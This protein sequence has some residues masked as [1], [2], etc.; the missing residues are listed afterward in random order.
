MRKQQTHST[1]ARIVAYATLVM[2]TGSGMAIAQAPAPVAAPPPSPSANGADP[3]AKA[4]KTFSP[5]ELEQLLAPIALYPDSLL[6]QTLMASTYPL[7]V[8]SAER[9]L[10]AN[11]SLKGKALE[12][13][14]QKQTWDASVKSLMVFPQVL[15]MMSQKLDWT[16]KLGDAF[17]AQK[18]DVMATA[19]ALR[20]K[21]VA[22]G[23][24][25]DSTEQKVVT[26]KSETTTIIK[27][28]PSNPEVVYVPTYN[29]AVVYGA[30]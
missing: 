12:D 27:I 19:Q 9:W 23:T 6:A 4:E 13:A 28:E 29:P 11:P 26:E 25:K 15:N 14:L 7:E 8:V 16:Q 30:W 2:F 1:A 17:L 10:K 20:T 21:A 5:Q 3:A 22:E 24:L 18:Q